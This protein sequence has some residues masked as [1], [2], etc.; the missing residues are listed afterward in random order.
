MCGK[1]KLDGARDI[2]ARHYAE[3][4]LC[5]CLRALPCPVAERL[6]EYA[7]HYTDRIAHYDAI[8]AAANGPT[9]VLE[10][11]DVMDKPRVQHIAGPVHGLALCGALLHRN[12]AGL[13]ATCEMCWEIYHRERAE[14]KRP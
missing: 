11:A 2:A 12:M 13:V 14:G 5:A 4:P 9:L 1:H 6:A 3:G 10:N 8:V 7:R